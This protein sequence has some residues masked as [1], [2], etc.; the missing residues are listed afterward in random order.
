MDLTSVDEVRQARTRADVVVGGDV[1]PLAGGTALYAGSTAR[2]LVDLTSLGW[3]AVE[4]D[5]DGVTIAATCTVAELVALPPVPGWRS[6]HLV[7]TCARA[8]VASTKIWAAATVGGNVCTA[9]PAGGMTTLLVALD[10]VALVWTPDGGERHV[11]V[12]ELVTGDGTTA[13]ADGEVLR[14]LHVGRPAMAAHAVLRRVSLAPFGRSGAIVTGRTDP[15]GSVVV[16][17]TAGVPRPYR[18]AF[19]A[20]PEAAALVAAV[21]AAVPAWFD[22]VHGAPDWRR[23]MTLRMAGQVHAALAA[24]GGPQDVPHE[25]WGTTR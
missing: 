7:A 25:G 2:V 23:A 6:Q 4:V 17:L 12:A 3:P 5:D 20:L 16:T 8:L 22:D 10:A 13:L 1:V 21:D 19:P 11:P 14:S 15:D 24:G 9:L 18:L